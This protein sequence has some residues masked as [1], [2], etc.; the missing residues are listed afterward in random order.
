HLDTRKN[1]KYVSEWFDMI[2]EGEHDALVE[3]MGMA[4]YVRVKFI[5]K[6][7]NHIKDMTRDQV[8]D[9][10]KAYFLKKDFK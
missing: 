7:C 3:A 6:S 5:G 2:L 4:N 9:L 1:G 8:A 10:R